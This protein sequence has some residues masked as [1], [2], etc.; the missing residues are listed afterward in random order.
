MKLSTSAYHLFSRLPSFDVACVYVLDCAQHLEPAKSD[1]N[2]VIRR[3]SAQSLLEISEGAL[4]FVA[5]DVQQLANEASCLAAFIG[6]QLVGYLWFRDGHIPASMNTPGAPFRGFDL[7]L[8]DATQYLFKVFV[9][10]QY[11]GYRINQLL[12]EELARQLAAQGYKHLVTLTA[13][14]NAAFRRSAERMGFEKLGQCVEVTTHKKSIYYFAADN[15][16][17]VRFAVPDS[18]GEKQPLED[19]VIEA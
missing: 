10:E 15:P 2:V 12:C 14:E 13:W 16:S 11:R 8:G 1:V 18:A 19:K 17:I 3:V 7:E 6:D 4:G 5:Q 9:D